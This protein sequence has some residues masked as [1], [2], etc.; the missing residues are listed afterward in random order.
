[1]SEST[2][3][4]FPVVGV[5]GVYA[6]D[7]DAYFSAHYFNWVA[8]KYA[9]A[10]KPSPKTPVFSRV[11]SPDCEIATIERLELSERICAIAIKSE[12]PKQKAMV[13]TGE[14]RRANYY[15]YYAPV[16]MPDETAHQL[17]KLRKGLSMSNIEAIIAERK[18]QIAEEDYS[19]EHDDEHT[20]GQLAAAASSYAFAASVSDDSRGV[21]ENS[22]EDMWPSQWPFALEEWKPT[23]RGEAIDRR[24]GDLKK[25]GALI[26]AEMARLDRLEAKQKGKPA[27]LEFPALE[28]PGVDLG[29]PAGSKGFTAPDIDAEGSP[30]NMESNTNVKG[31]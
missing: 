24:R 4:R 22:P 17:Y 16:G 2:R 19:F 23:N 3:M 10:M 28:L 9:Y 18:R 1:M 11:M 7:L 6:V 29:I 25:A 30:V 26:L 12:T 8:G 14:R 13:A 27:P 20:S 21:L 5:P 15:F 31:V